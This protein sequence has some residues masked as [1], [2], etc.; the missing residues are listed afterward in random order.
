[1]LSL[2][3]FHVFLGLVQL[4]S[5]PE[6]VDDQFCVAAAVRKVITINVR[7]DLDM[8]PRTQEFHDSHVCPDTP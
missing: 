6:L 2:L 8:P 5:L 3:F 4:S 7:F 1:M